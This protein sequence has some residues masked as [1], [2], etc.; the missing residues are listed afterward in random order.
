MFHTSFIQNLIKIVEWLMK[1][2]LLLLNNFVE[3]KCGTNE[4]QASTKSCSKQ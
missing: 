1:K 3:R 2:K 4:G